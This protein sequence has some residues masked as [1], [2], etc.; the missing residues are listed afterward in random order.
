MKEEEGGGGGG[1]GLSRLSPA[2]NHLLLP[3]SPSVSS[4]VFCLHIMHAREGKGGGWR[5]RER[6]YRPPNP[7]E[8]CLLLLLLLLPSAAANAWQTEE[9]W[10]GQQILVRK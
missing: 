9:A 2:S 8:H 5:G 1:G 6:L 10:I 4:F 3:S 7:N